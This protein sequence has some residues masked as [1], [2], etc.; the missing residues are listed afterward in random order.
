MAHSKISPIEELIEEIRVG[1][2]VVMTDDEDREN[3]GDLIFAADKVSPELVN[4][5]M[6]YGRGLICVPLS[7]EKV[8]TLG[9]GA[10]NPAA[11]D[12]MGT[13]F[14]LSVDAMKGIS[15]GIS[16]FD[17]SRTI[18]VL[19]NAS[20]QRSDLAVPGHVFP[21]IAK[22]GG[23]LRRAGHTEAAVDLAKL[24]GLSPAG[25]ICEIVNDD[26]TMSRLPDLLR[27]CSEHHLK[28]GTIRDLIEYRRKKEK[29][30]ARVNE[31][32]MSSD[33]SGWSILTYQSVIDSAEHV[34]LVKGPITG[35]ALARVTGACFA[36]DVMDAIRKKPQSQL[37]AALRMI[38]RE[39]QGVILY[40]NQS[41]KAISMAQNIQNKNKWVCLPEHEIS[42]SQNQ[43]ELRDYGIGA[44]ILKDLGCR[45]LKI[46]TN[47]PRKLISLEGHGLHVLETIAFDFSSDGA[48]T[49]PS[50]NLQSILSF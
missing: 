44:Q 14:T 4:F 33:H 31:A 7:S 39:G 26:G 5:M 47:H 50:F 18:E 9:L 42:E 37:L 24:A 28:F 40:V 3:E 36:D 23:V 20:S 29:L 17:R 12:S 8:K 19:A 15:T 27:F 38:E 1:R 32:A 16:A 49:E 48:Q 11:E 6:R 13:A 45:E 22:D 2:M 25:V 35:T 43:T 41:S 34:A 30:V 10:M 46:M 21:L